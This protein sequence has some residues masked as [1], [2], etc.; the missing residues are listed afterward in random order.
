MRLAAQLGIVK[1]K[2]QGCTRDK[3][4]EPHLVTKSM[5]LL[6]QPNALIPLQH[7]EDSLTLTLQLQ[8]RPLELPPGLCFADTELTAPLPVLSAI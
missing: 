5:V 6:L 3:H 2:G 1:A 4:D 7:K 8:L